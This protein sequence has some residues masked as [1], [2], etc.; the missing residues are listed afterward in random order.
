M[1]IVTIGTGATFVYQATSN[2]NGNDLSENGEDMSD[3]SYSV[4]IPTMFLN[5]KVSISP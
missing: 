1:I 5:V 2:A 4:D 3:A